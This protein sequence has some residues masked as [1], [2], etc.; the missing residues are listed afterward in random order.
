MV[1][2]RFCFLLVELDARGRLPQHTSGG[3]GGRVCLG[4]GLL[5]L[6]ARERPKK[7]RPVKPPVEL[8]PKP[9]RPKLSR[10]APKPK[11]D[12][13][14]E[15]L[16]RVPLG[17]SDWEFTELERQLHA[18]YQRG[19]ADEEM[20]RELCGEYP[21][22]NAKWIGRWRAAKKLPTH[23]QKRESWDHV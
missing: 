8:K 20:V 19:A 18:L 11:D 14:D 17:M 1:H 9:S 16:S 6:S 10:P 22:L 12:A 4:V 5:A 23:K 7:V 15:P 21:R 13:E 3:I 2:C